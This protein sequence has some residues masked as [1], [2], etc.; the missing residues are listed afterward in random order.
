L[1]EQRVNGVIKRPSQHGGN[2]FQVKRYP[3]AVPLMQ[4]IAARN[5]LESRF[6]PAQDS[7]TGADSRVGRRLRS[8]ICHRQ[9]KNLPE[10]SREY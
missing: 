3:R 7:A 10:F 4:W 5:T 8:A 1:I 6:T 9:R 2:D